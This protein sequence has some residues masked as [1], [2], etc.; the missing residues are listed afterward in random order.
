M[1]KSVNLFLLIFIFFSALL[2][3]SIYAQDHTDEG[4]SVEFE[5][6]VELEA[7][8]GI[9][10]DS[11]LYFIESGILEK[12]RD[13]IDNRE[14]KIAEIRAMIQQGKIEEARI[15]LERYK[16][17][18]DN[19]QREVSPEDRER[20][21]RSASAVYNTLKD[22]EDEI[23]DD[24]REEFFENIVDRER[25][26]VTS[27]DIASKIKE[28]CE[29]LSQLDPLEYS[30][31]CKT[32]D[33][34]PEWQK[35]LDRDLT[36]E[37]REEAQKFGRIMQ[38]CFETAG[39]Q[40]A[41][42]EIPFADF[43]KMCSIAAP[44]AT[45]CEIEGN[46]EACKQLDD[47]EMPELPEHLQD[48]FD[49]LESDISESRFDLHMPPE[50][51][52]AGV[53]N[54]SEC[55]RI[56]IQTNAPEECR[57]ALLA[58]DVQNEREG[59]E[60]CEKI[61][62]ELNAPQECIDAGLTDHRECGR[63]MFELNAPQE[64]IDAGLTGE[65]RN[66]PRKCEEIMRSLEGEFRNGPQGGFGGNCR[67]IQ[68]P[69]ERLACYDGALQGAGEQR[70]FDERR[71][72]DQGAMRMCAEN[73]LSQG[74][75]WDFSKGNCECRFPE[76]FDDSRFRE[77]DFQEGEFVPPEEFNEI[78]PSEKCSQEGG[79]WD[80]NTCTFSGSEGTTDGG[81]EEDTTTEDISGITGSVVSVDRFY[82]YYFR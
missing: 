56:M 27:A 65:H 28:L 82:N 18:A 51:R 10:P 20:A 79:S 70:S 72:E 66:D 67:A 17:H 44:L 59:R 49:N 36:G 30:R 68:N 74:A 26:I 60:I 2:V 12:F 55:R 80:G 33:N 34:N 63:F 45:A 58:A 47:L 43:A 5:E 6:G 77:R 3:T 29:S 38:Q 22:I 25:S 11:G 24:E 40:C 73:C 62:F 61:M 7:S 64:C 37:Q 81:T 76:R 15:A 46:E 53:T 21:Q 13:D 39:Q 42:E 75:A 54:P 41:C 71:R 52:E 19:L 1:K 35:K 23:P 4:S 8:E 69:E 9:T 78:S 31:V 14:K 48:V 50:C 16:E 57:E 32:G